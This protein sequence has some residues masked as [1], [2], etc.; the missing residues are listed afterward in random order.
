MEIVLATNNAHK[1]REISDGFLGLPLKTIPLSDY[2]DAPELKEEGETYAENALHKAR[3]VARMTH[4]WALGDDTGLEVDALDGAP[5]LYSARYAGEGV[6][7]EQNRKKLLDALK[8]V[9]WEKRTALFRC[10]MA[11]AG[12]SGEEAVFEGTVSGTIT[13][14]DRG[15]A[16]FG[17]DPIFFL[18]GYNKTFAEMDPTEKNRISHRALALQKVKEHLKTIA[19][20]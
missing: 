14:E 12:P 2:P 7:F 17:Y 1:V 8:G 13:E 5:G 3:T 4:R 16:G 10:V 11:L 20:V 9:R 15:D 18:P 6:T 19:V